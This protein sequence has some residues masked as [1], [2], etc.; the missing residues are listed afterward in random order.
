MEKLIYASIGMI[1]FAVVAMIIYVVGDYI[2]STQSQE[3]VTVIERMYEAASVGT[4]VGI[5][6]SGQSGLVVT[7]KGPEYDLLLEFEDGHREIVS[8]DEDTLINVDIG[9]SVEMTCH[10]GG[11]SETLL[12]CEM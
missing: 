10:Y 11:W 2:T 3:R 6:S 12:T 9:D 8:T 7:S 1:M 4:G 5:T